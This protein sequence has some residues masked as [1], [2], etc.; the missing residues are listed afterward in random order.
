MFKTAKFGIK[1]DSNG[2]FHCDD[3]PAFIGET[4]H[5]WYIHGK[6]HRLD[7]P[8]VVY[9]DGPSSWWIN[10]RCVDKQIKSWADTQGI[11]LDNLSDN[12]KVLIKLTWGDYG[13]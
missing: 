13:K 4:C 5:S 10:G 2:A 1:V 3:G 9:N 12:D 8:A 11:D 6:K 7:G